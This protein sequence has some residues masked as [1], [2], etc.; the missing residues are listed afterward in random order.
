MKSEYVA[1]RK[2]KSPPDTID[3][4]GPTVRRGP[5]GEVRIFSKKGAQSLE[6]E[7][8]PCRRV[9]K[10]VGRQRLRARQGKE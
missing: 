4:G 7:R 2:K 6:I 8:N 10:Q 1:V 9:I 3:R 5:S